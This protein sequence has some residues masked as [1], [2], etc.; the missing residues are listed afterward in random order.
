VIMLDERRF[1]SFE[2]RQ[3]LR[4]LFARPLAS[5]AWAKYRRM[6]GVPGKVKSLTLQEVYSLAACCL[7]SQ[8]RQPVSERAI[9]AI[10][11]EMPDIVGLRLATL[12]GGVVAGRDVIRMP[13]EVTGW[14]RATWYRRGIRANTGYRPADLR[15]LSRA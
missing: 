12:T 8:R 14:S 3:I 1:D 11:S 4:L 10:V 2:C 5:E 13:R 9:A 15:R 6:A 7:L